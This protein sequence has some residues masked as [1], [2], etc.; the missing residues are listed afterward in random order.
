MKTG[1]IPLVGAFLIVSVGTCRGLSSDINSDGVVNLVDVALVARDWL[2]PV[3][4]QRK[5]AERDYIYV[6]QN[7]LY[8]ASGQTGLSKGANIWLPL[9]NTQG[10][11]QFWRLQRHNSFRDGVDCWELYGHYACRVVRGTYV[12]FRLSIRMPTEFEWRMELDRGQFDYCRVNRMWEGLCARRSG[13]TLGFRVPFDTKRLYLIGYPSTDGGRAA[14]FRHGGEGKITKHI[15]NWSSANGDFGS[16]FDEFFNSCL[17]IATDL[18]DQPRIEI[19]VLEGNVTI[20]GLVAVFDDE[21][22]E[23]NEGVFDPQSMRA[24]LPH[25]QIAEGPIRLNFNKDSKNAFWWGMGHWWQKGGNNTLLFETQ[26]LFVG[27][28]GDRWNAPEVR[29]VF[30]KTNKFERVLRGAVRIYNP[31]TRQYFL[32]GNYEGAYTFTCS[33]LSISQRWVFNSQAERAGVYIDGALAGYAG[34]WA[35]NGEYFDRAISLPSTSKPVEV[36]PPWDGA[37]LCDRNSFSLA[38]YGRASRLLAL[39]DVHYRFSG[40]S[41]TVAF[42]QPRGFVYKRLEG[43]PKFYCPAAVGSEHRRIKDGD[44]IE[45]FQQ[46]VV[47]DIDSYSILVSER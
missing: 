2:E 40:R 3:P 46:R 29:K 4:Q 25:R 18:K 43:F 12:P 41:G 20:C 14:V 44:C 5:T 7:Y 1:W 21:P 31:T 30:V 34:Q 22:A 23:P 36:G 19:V 8:Q 26:D 42:G 28:N 10:S 11:W 15:L 45:S 6:E 17:L 33:G 38:M 47:T 32:I 39:F 9:G 16:E 27:L 24:L 37:L 13:L 35:L